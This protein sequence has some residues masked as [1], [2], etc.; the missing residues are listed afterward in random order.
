MAQ[1]S[2]KELPIILWS[3]SEKKLRYDSQ[4]QG[5]CVHATLSG[6]TCQRCEIF[7]SD[8][9]TMFLDTS[10]QL[11]WGHEYI[12]GRY[13]QDGSQYKVYSLEWYAE[14]ILSGAAA[15]DTNDPQEARTPERF[16]KALKELTTPEPFDF[17]TFDV[18]A[19]MDEMVSELNIPFASLCRHHCLPFVGVAHVAY[20]PGKV[21]AGISK[22]T[23][24]VQYYAHKLQTQEELTIEI[25]D[26]LV[27]NLSKQPAEDAKARGAVIYPPLGVAV[28]LE[29]EHMCQTIRGARTPG[30][31]TRTA[32]MRGVFSQH[33][34]T[35]KQEFLSSI[36]SHV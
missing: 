19:S 29:A 24:T 11:A 28:V 35:A 36:N 6:F 10:E 9:L 33:D 18:P 20:I 7:Q 8:M 32:A 17:T 12:K 34:K 1:G 15:L 14:L 26:S 30:T 16:I 13:E 27:T 22:L 5:E 21:M 2:E 4:Q 23:R 3:S 31:K 25:A